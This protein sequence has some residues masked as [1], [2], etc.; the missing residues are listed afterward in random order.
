MRQIIFIGALSFFLVA[1]ADVPSDRE[2]QIQV[3]NFLLKDNNYELYDIENF[4][5]VNGFQQE[6]NT[7]IAHIKYELMFKKGLDDL[8]NSLDSDEPS[9]LLDKGLAAV[10]MV[11]LTAQYG[12]F[13]AGDRLPR[14]E[15]VT[16]IKTEQ[17]W[18][19]K[20]EFMED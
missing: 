15:K 16:L 6:D 4:V 5:K 14:D 19:L 12:N 1:C 7:Y 11:A 3:S 9:S 13:K 18:R 17:G 8:A 20:Q 2:I 10:G